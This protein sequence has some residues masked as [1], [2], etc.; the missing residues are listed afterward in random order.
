[1]FKKISRL[2][3]NLY[4]CYLKLF[5][6]V[7]IG[8]GNIFQGKPLIRGGSGIAIGDR[9]V[10]CSTSNYTALGVSKSVM[11]QICEPNGAVRI[12]SDNGFSGTVICSSLSVE[13]GS[14]CLFGA[15]VTI[16]DTDFHPIEALNR[17]YEKRGI[18]SKRVKINDNVFV[19][20][21]VVIC[22]GV[23]IGENSVIGTGSVVLSDIP[24][25][26]I[27]AGNPCKFIREL[28]VK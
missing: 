13:I 8:G 5:T 15:D 2:V 4:Y 10:F 7:T 9:N 16:F 1:M 21:G 3:G 14:N 17:R 25:N 18:K 24:S 26:C 11:I 23:E 12:G 22:K 28:D 6:S 27:A 20:T 19:G